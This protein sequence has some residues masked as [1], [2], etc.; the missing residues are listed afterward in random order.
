MELMRITGQP[1]TQGN[2][3]GATNLRLLNYTIGI[4]IQEANASTI[5]SWS[6]KKVKCD[7]VAKY[8]LSSNNI[9]YKK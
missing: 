1:K 9:F 8:A 3:N 2:G 6:I 7:E 4:K 5:S